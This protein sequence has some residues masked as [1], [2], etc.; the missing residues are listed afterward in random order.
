MY[1]FTYLY[2]N[3]D[4]EQCIGFHPLPDTVRDRVLRRMWVCNRLNAKGRLR[5]SADLSRCRVV[6]DLRNL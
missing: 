4:G 2:M 5:P 1:R 3:E 6:S